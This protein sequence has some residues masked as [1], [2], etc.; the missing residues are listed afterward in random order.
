MKSTLILGALVGLAAAAP[1]PQLIDLEG[2]AAIEIPAVGPSSDVTVA[3]PD[4]FD[5]VA[6]IRAAAESIQTASAK[7]KRT[8]GDC[9]P[10][11]S[12][13]V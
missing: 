5:A 9:A 10:Q 1:R 13:C 12:K 2:V 4:A 7:I 6:V 11:Q 3:Q 8:E